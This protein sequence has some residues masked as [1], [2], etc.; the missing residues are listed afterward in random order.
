MEKKYELIVIGSGPAGE[1]AAVKA[2]YFGHK[3][4][5]IEKEAYFGGAGVHTGTLPSKTLK[6]TALYYSGKTDKGLYGVERKLEH[7]ASVKDFLYR[8]NIIVDSINDEVHQNII[9]HNVDIYTGDGSFVDE[10]R[11]KV[12]GEKEEVIYGENILIATGSYP[13]Q[14]SNIPFD[15][16]RIH[17]SDS[18][19]ELTNFPKSI[20]IVGAGVIGCEYTTIF[21]AMGAKV[22]LIN[23]RDKILPF[24][25]DDITNELVEQ[26]KKDGIEILFNN[27]FTDIEVPES[28]QDLIKVSMK[29]GDP[30][31]VDMFLFAAGRSA[32]TRTLNCEAAG[33]K[34]GKREVVEVNEKY[35]SSVPHIFAVGDVIGFP[36]LASTSMDQGR[37]AISHIFDI[38]DLN[39]ISTVLPYGIYTIPEVSMIGITQEEAEAQEIEYC[40][41]IARHKDMPRGRIMGVEDGF[42][43]IIFSR[44]DLRILGVHIIGPLASELIHY[45]MT[46]V[47]NES[48]VNDVLRAVF[49]Y[50]TLHDLYKYACYDGLGNLTGHKIKK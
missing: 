29:D 20:C 19:L 42:L 7:E 5:I 30:I 9:I 32:N 13:F 8:K 33:V 23:N 11:V 46:L 14:P 22:Y 24:L 27:S 15:Q 43:K 47:H 31:N 16:K 21:A 36:A 37:V 44:D 2:A 4:A 18:I 38:N 26:M 35:Q 45:G 49:N 28:D 6:E 41:G 12:S 50:P 25:D 39:K 10:H 48:K 1:K 34:L 17:D 3:V 40:T